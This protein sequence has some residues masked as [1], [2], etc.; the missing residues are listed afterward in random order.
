M[1]IDAKFVYEHQ[2]D[3]TAERISSYY[4]TALRA[5]ILLDK[6]PVSVVFGRE[7]R[8]LCLLSFILEFQGNTTKDV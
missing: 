7:L 8:F 5:M 2:K 1:L 4:L 3:R 6:Q